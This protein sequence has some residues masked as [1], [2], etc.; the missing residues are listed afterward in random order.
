[1]RIHDFHM[2]DDRRH[3]HDDTLPHDGPFEDDAVDSSS[4]GRG[5]HRG[6]RHGGGRGPRFAGPGAGWGGP[7]GRGRRRRP[8]GAVREAV[9]SLL[10]EG[11][12][13]GYGLMREIDQR[14][15]GIWTPSPGSMY[16]TLAQLVDEGLIAPTDGDKGTDFVLTQRGQDHVADNADTI[17][18]VWSDGSSGASSHVALRDSVQ[19]LLDVAHQFRFATDD[20]RSRATAQLDTTRKALHRMLA[21]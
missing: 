6:A 15:Q 4:R 11:P 2:E 18:Q 9:L 3:H 19:A 17:A 5:R 13:N 8:K 21:E 1:M 7:G 10:A 14:T 20:Q 12:A 16:P